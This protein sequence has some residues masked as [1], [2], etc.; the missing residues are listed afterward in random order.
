MSLAG[1]AALVTGGGRGIGAAT[2]LAVETSFDVTVAATND[3][4]IVDDPGSKGG[5]EDT[6]ATFTVT[7]I[8]PG[9]GADEAAQLVTVTATHNAPGL[10]A[11]VSTGT[12]TA[13]S[14]TLTAEERDAVRAARK[15][16]GKGAKGKGG[17]GAAGAPGG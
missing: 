4:P 5:L 15:G 1:R 13:G 12:V 9:G 7:G 8:G 2:A 17:V 16:A 3:K 6:P 14:M 10:I 11:S